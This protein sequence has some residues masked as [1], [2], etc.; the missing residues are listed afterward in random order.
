MNNSQ[1]SKTTSKYIK[2]KHCEYRSF[3]G[4]CAEIA[5]DSFQ[6]LWMRNFE[7]EVMYI[8]SMHLYS[9]DEVEPS[10]GVISVNYAWTYRIAFRVKREVAAVAGFEHK[11]RCITISVSA[12]KCCSSI[13]TR[14]TNERTSICRNYDE[15]STKLHTS[16]G[17]V[18]TICVERQIELARFLY[19]KKR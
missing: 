1:T 17:Q 2:T 14:Y 5:Y 15:L 18:S 12:F 13:S 11:M 7:Y 6:W 19:N 3:S 16:K 9:W 4:V 10:F 8:C